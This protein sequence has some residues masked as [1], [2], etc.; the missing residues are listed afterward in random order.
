MFA[1][2]QHLVGVFVCAFP[3]KKTQTKKLVE[4]K[5]DYDLINQAKEVFSVHQENPKTSS[6][7]IRCQQKHHH[8]DSWRFCDEE[9]LVVETILNSSFILQFHFRIVVKLAHIK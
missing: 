5:E 6:G 2:S 8:R 1:V 4:E 7:T 9:L 3:K